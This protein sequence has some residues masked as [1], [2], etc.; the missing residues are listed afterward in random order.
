M[1]TV[2]KIFNINIFK[3]VVFFVLCVFAINDNL[4]ALPDNGERKN[5]DKAFIALI[6]MKMMILPGTASY[7]KKSLEQATSKGAKLAILNLDTPGGLLNST[8]EIVQEMFNSKIPVIVFISP[9]GAS[10]TS[11]GVFITLASDVAVMTKGSSIGAAHPVGSA[12][13]DVKGDMREKV[14]NMAIAMIKSIAETRNKN[15]N[16]A[17]DAVKKSISVTASQ[18]LKENVID[19]L[20]KDTKDLLK[21]LSGRTIKFNGQDFV[22]DDYSELPIKK[23]EMSLQDKILNILSNP[24][25]AVLLWLGAVTGLALELYHPGAILPGLIGTICLIL[26]MI[27]NQVIPISVGAL[28]LIIAGFIMIGFEL[29]VTSGLLGIFG[30]IAVTLGSL[31]LVDLSKFPELAVNPWIILPSAIFLCLF[32][33]LIACLVIRTMGKKS[34]VGINSLVGCIGSVTSDFVG[35]D[36]KGV[37]FLDGTYWNAVSSEKIKKGDSVIVVSNK[38]GLL[39]E[40]VKVT[41]NN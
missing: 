37:I 15:A 38:N 23:F 40:V 39:L 14:E 26:A 28:M 22:F 24:S 1:N 17:Q 32:F 19:F 7:F 9:D 41:K 20:A 11:A 35:E 12:G 2:K 4:Y 31:S 21:K 13:Q 3:F 29:Y 10:A 8:Q 5:D 36:N 25:I 33:I 18:A 6:D 30:V 16:W 34:R 27:V